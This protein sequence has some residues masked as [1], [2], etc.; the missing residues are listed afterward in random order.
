M[1]L[2]YCDSDW[3]EDVDERKNTTGFFF[4]M[5]S[6]TLLEVQLLLGS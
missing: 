4:Y 5:G 6:V 2:G 3:V 1:L